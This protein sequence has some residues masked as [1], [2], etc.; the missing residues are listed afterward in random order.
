MKIGTDCMQEKHAWKV[1]TRGYCVFS[2]LKAAIRCDISFALFV[3]D[4][5]MDI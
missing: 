4:T 5:I 3:H 1:A 2:H